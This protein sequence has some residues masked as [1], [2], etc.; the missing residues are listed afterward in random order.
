MVY[1]LPGLKCDAFK[2]NPAPAG[3]VRVFKMRIDQKHI[4]A[5][6]SDNKPERALM[7]I[8]MKEAKSQICKMS[9]HTQ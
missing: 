1:V 3:G 2:L 5:L 9:A 7:R 6:F 4:N 8:F